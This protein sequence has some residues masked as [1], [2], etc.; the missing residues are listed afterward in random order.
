MA[1]SHPETEDLEHEILGRFLDELDGS[2]GAVSSESIERFD[3]AWP[4][5]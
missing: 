3:A 2:F 4:S 5:Q 1:H